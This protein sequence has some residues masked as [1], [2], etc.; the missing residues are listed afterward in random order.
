MIELS[1]EQTEQVR[2]FINEFMQLRDKNDI[3]G[4]RAWRERVVQTFPY[5]DP[6]TLL[7]T[8]RTIMETKQ[9]TE[10]ED[11]EVLCG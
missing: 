10:L 8:I 9:Q 11:L 4:I 7:V 6:N 5:E 2:T 1:K 3:E